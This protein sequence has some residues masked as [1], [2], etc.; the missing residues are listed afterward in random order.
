MCFRDSSSA[1]CDP[2]KIL[3]ALNYA[4]NI[5]LQVIGG[6]TAEEKNNSVFW[7]NNLRTQSCLAA[8]TGADIEARKLIADAGITALSLLFTGGFG[9][10]ARGTAGAISFAGAVSI[11]SYFAVKGTEDAIRACS[12][13]GKVTYDSKKS[14][15]T[16]PALPAI[17]N[18]SFGDQESCKFDVIMAAVG[19][20]PVGLGVSQAS[21]V[22]KQN[23]N[24]KRV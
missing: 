11:D 2:K 5:E 17:N 8:W 1:F 9:L 12:D 22:V 7:N 16:C 6:E 14:E 10:M 23:P 15:P 21:K 3:N 20:V 19:I 13:T 24:W 4:P 18:V